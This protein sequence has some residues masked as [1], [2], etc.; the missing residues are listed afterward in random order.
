MKI[1]IKDGL[2]VNYSV[3]IINAHCP[4]RKAFLQ[5]FARL[6]GMIDKAMQPEW[7]LIHKKVLN[8]E[9]LTFGEEDALIDRVIKRIM[10]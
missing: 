1:P 5:V 3:G 8:K 9:P 4:E 7:E 6:V 2:S 10:E